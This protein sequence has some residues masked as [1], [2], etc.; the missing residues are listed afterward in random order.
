MLW[1][2]LPAVVPIRLLI[3]SKLFSLC[4]QLC[5]QLNK[6]CLLPY[7]ELH[8][9]Q[10][11]WRSSVLKL[12]VLPSVKVHATPWECG[13]CCIQVLEPDLYQYSEESGL[14]SFLASNSR[15]SPLCEY[16][17]FTFRYQFSRACSSLNVCSFKLHCKCCFHSI[18]S[19]CAFEWSHFFLQESQAALCYRMLIVTLINISQYKSTASAE[20][21]RLSP[22]YL[23]KRF[24]SLLSRCTKHVLCQN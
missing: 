6:S 18:Y 7:L 2:I 19:F 24:F 17:K 4:V 15:N 3:L 9:A 14:F 11:L 13:F 10:S 1:T 8:G 16:V 22:M 5:Y 20:E 12:I 21:I 23:R